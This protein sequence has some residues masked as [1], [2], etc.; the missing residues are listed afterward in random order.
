M[1]VKLDTVDRLQKYFSGVVG[2]SDHH[3]PQVKQII[4]G[5]LGIIVLKKDHGT[6]IEVRGT[7]E[8]ETGNILW[9]MINGVRYAF[10]YEHETGEIEI[11]KNTYNGPILL[12]VKN[13]TT[14]PDI[15]DVLK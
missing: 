14:I 1:A 5:L 13:S 10:R 7:H 11:R 6:E 8:D 9:V 12:A 2:R 3:A 4:Y 15:L